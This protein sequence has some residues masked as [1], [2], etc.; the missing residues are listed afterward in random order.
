MADSLVLTR[1]TD[2]FDFSVGG[3]SASALVGSMAAGLVAMVARLS[4]NGQFGMAPSRCR[5]LAEEADGLSRQLLQGAEAD[6]EAYG[7]LAASYR[8]PRGSPDCQEARE[9]AILRAAFVAASVPRDN[10]RRVRRVV[11]LCC[12]LDGRSNP[13]AGTDLVVAR[14]LAGAALVGCVHN[15]TVN[16]PLIHDAYFAKELDHEAS[17]LRQ[18]AIREL[19][20]LATGEDA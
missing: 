8:L 7:L 4:Q 15:I 18:I 20:S 6:A 14:A 5:S 3:G 12:E 10:A 13:S 1:I 2:S 9:A 11:E 17:Q 16:L 19:T